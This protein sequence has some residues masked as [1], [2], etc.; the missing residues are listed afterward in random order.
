[1]L[2]SISEQSAYNDTFAFVQ[3]NNKFSWE[4]TVYCFSY[5]LDNRIKKCQIHRYTSFC[6]DCWEILKYIYRIS[7]KSNQIEKD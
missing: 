3:G 6:N 1:M 5:K 2:V 4:N 7:I